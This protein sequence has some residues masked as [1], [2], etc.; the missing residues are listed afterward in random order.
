MPMKPEEIKA[1]ILQALPDAQITLE[2]S[3]GDNDHYSAVI[4][5]KAFHGKTKVQQH[6]L[7]Y[8]ALQGNMGTTLHAMALKTSCPDE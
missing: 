6:Q 4:I 2:D 3:L 7:V 8:Q 1:L 5:S